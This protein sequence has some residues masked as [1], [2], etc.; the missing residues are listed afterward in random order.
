MVDL[1]STPRLLG[2]LLPPTFIILL[3][4]LLIP[5]FLNLGPLLELDLKLCIS[6]LLLS[7]ISLDLLQALDPQ[8]LLV[9]NLFLIAEHL[10]LKLLI[11]S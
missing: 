6:S 10:E 8:V 7:L 5:R 4:P 9:E 3:L 11:E 1:D 2:I